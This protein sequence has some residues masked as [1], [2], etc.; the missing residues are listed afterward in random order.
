MGNV[1]S[2]LSWWYRNSMEIFQF[3]TW[4]IFNNITLDTFTSY[5]MVLNWS[6]VWNYLFGKLFTFF[7]KKNL[8]TN[9]ILVNIFP[10]VYCTVHLDLL[11]KYAWF[12]Y[13]HTHYREA[14]KTQL[15]FRICSENNRNTYIVINSNMWITIIYIYILNHITNDYKWT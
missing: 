13:T 1:L 8:Y 15:I 7:R 9:S 11:F 5:Q 2:V 14:F 12:T 6:Y 3:W 4:N 10:I